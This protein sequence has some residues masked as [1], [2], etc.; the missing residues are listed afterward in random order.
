M[1]HGDFPGYAGVDPL[2]QA[3][4]DWDTWNNHEPLWGPMRDM[5]LVAE[6]AAAGFGSD[7]VRSVTVPT[8]R[9]LQTGQQARAG[10]LWL[11]VGAR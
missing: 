1:V 7:R 9:L 2:T 5:D 8:T 3:M 6:A 11:L 4:I 10:Q